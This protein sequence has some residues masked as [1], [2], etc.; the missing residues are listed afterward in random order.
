MGALVR[1]AVG[2]KKPC[3]VGVAGAG[4]RWRG[5]PVGRVLSVQGN[6]RQLGQQWDERT[7]GGV[8]EK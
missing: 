1:S 8:V 2:L 6:L 3:Q 5:R 7:E 4:G